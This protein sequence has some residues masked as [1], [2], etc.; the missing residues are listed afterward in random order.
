MVK[1]ARETLKEIGYDEAILSEMT[2]EDCENEIQEIPY[3]V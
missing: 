2:D 1:T 3:N